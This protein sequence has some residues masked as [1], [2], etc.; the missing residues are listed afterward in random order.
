MLS[1][2]HRFPS[3][4]PASTDSRTAKASIV[5]LGLASARTWVS[6]G[7]HRRAARITAIFAFVVTSVAASVLHA[8]PALPADLSDSFG[9]DGRPKPPEVPTTALTPWHV[10]LKAG[11]MLPANISGMGGLLGLEARYDFHPRFSVTLALQ[12]TL[13]LMNLE[14]A[15]YYDGNCFHPTLHVVPSVEFHPLTSAFDPWIGLG[16]GVAYTWSSASPHQS[17]AS[18]GAELVPGAG[19]NLRLGAFELG[20]YSMGLISTGPTPSAFGYGFK[21]GVR[22]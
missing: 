9:T 4:F 17:V 15:C 6:P 3:V 11:Q 14:G 21:A 12:Q 2:V 1:S 20:L 18:W 13:E 7:H 16:G 19:V 22:L 10:A 5:A 8:A